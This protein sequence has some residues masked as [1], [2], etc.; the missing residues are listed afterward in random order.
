MSRPDKGFFAVSLDSFRSVCDRLDMNE[1]CLYLIYCCGSDRTNTKTSWSINALT[2]YTAIS[3]RRA[4]K[5]ASLLAKHGY[6]TKDREGKH[7]KFTINRDK[8]GETVWIPKTFVWGASDETPPLEHLR[9]TGDHMILRL[10]F[11]LYWQCDIAEDGGIRDLWSVYDKEHIAE[12]AQFN[13]IGFTGTSLKLV[14]RGDLTEPHLDQEL[15]KP[16]QPFWDRLDILIDLGLIYPVPTLFDSQD[17]EVVVPIIDP[18]D[19]QPIENF[20]TIAHYVLPEVMHY[21]L[22]KNEFNLLVQKTMKSVVLKGMY[23]L[24]YRQHTAKT[25]AGYAKT[26]ERICLYQRD[27]KD[28]SRRYQGVNQG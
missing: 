6:V 17:G 15:E 10:V 5:A 18:F 8:D 26:K 11:D 24:R 27:I 23:V 28:V 19:Q 2:K 21:A 14:N 22:E 13:I 7:P 9:R 16:F 25:N 1:C 3:V 12:H 20:C 4:Q